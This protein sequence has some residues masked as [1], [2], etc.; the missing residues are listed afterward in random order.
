[1]AILSNIN[2]LFAVETTGAIKFN[3]LPGTNNQILKSNGNASPTW[4]TITNA[5]AASNIIGGPYL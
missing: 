1:M 5:A 2:D 3:S 4:V